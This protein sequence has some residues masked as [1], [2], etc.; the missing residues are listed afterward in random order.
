MLDSR[1]KRELDGALVGEVGYDGKLG[2]QG[3]SIAIAAIVM[4]GSVYC[5]GLFRHQ[6]SPAMSCSGL[7]FHVVNLSNLHRRD[8]HLKEKKKKKKKV[9]L[10]R[11]RSFWAPKDAVP[12][13]AFARRNEKPALT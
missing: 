4:A 12:M 2:Y 5:L 9:S 11:V 7:C 6:A 13:A 3:Q 10:A 8:F 1:R